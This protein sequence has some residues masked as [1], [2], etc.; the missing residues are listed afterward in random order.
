[1]IEPSL[2][3]PVVPPFFD[4]TIFNNLWTGARQGPEIAEIWRVS[5][6]VPRSGLD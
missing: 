1:L 5:G 2:L 4:S 6:L 3:G